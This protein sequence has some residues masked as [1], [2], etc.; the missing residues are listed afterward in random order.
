MEV[1]KVLV[2]MITSATSPELQ[3][4]VY[5]L[6]G[7]HYVIY[8]LLVCV[9]VEMITSEKKLSLAQVS[10]TVIRPYTKRETVKKTVLKQTLY[11][12]HVRHALQ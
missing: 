1:F 9:R 6:I 10:S 11:T 5:T 3:L 12:L 4:Y 2:M 7:H 8:R